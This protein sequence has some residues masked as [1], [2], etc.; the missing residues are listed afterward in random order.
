MRNK[1]E[2]LLKKKNMNIVDE[3]QL[4]VIGLEKSFTVIKDLTK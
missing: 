3:L 1:E 2:F 4:G